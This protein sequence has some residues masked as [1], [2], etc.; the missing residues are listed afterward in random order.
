M[1]AKVLLAFSKL[2]MNLPLIAEAHS[3]P[4]DLVAHA[5]LLGLH[6]VY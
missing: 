4:L 5:I 1:A 2:K 6:L 3:Y